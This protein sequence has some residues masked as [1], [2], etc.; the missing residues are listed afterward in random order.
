MAVLLD[1]FLET[2]SES[3]LM[4]AGR[5]QA[6]LDGLGADEKP[7]TGEELARLLVGHGKLTSFQAR[8]ICRGQTAGLVLGNY[9]VLDS[10]GAGGMGY[11][12]KARHE[13]MKRVVALKVLPSSLTEQTEAVERF[14]RE[15]EAAAKLVHRNIVVAHD[16]DEA[17]GLHF[18]VMEYVDGGD[19]RSLV[20]LIGTLAVGQAVDYILQA[21]QAL[22][23]AHQKQVIHRDVKPANLLLDR[24]GTIKL[25]DLGLARVET[26]ISPDDPTGS[27]SLTQLGQI[28]GT[29]DFMAPEQALD[30]KRAREPADVY[31]LGCTLFFLLTGRSLY[32]AATPMER[33]VAHR[34]QPIPSIR[35]LRSDVPESLDAVFRQMVAKR[36][37]DRQAS[38]TEVIAQLEACLPAE[39]RILGPWPYPSADVGKSAQA[40]SAAPADVPTQTWADD[41]SRSTGPRVES[42]SDRTAHPESKRQPRGK[43]AILVGGL[44]A[45]AA[46]GSVALTVV[47]RI[48]TPDGTLVLEISQ[49]GA[50]VVILDKDDQVEIERSGGPGSLQIS[51]DPGTY[52][53]EVQKEGFK[54]YTEHFTI[55]SNAAKELEAQLVPLAS[56]RTSKTTPDKGLE[57][58][59]TSPPPSSSR[60]PLT[61]APFS[62]E[63]AKQHQQVWGEYLGLPVEREIDL[64]GGVTLTTVL[65][66]PGEFLMGSKAEENARFMEKAKAASDQWTIAR[67]PSEGPQQL[68]RIGRPFWLS[69]YE[70]TR[71]QFRLF[72]DE[73]G[74]KTDA[75]R[76]KEGEG[77][78]AYIGGRPVRDPRFDWSVDPGFKQTD[79]HPVVNV[80]WNDAQ[81]FCKW[82]RQKQGGDRIVLP[83]EAQWEYACRAGTTT[84]WHCGDS[85]AVLQAYGWFLVN[86][87]GQTHPVGQL[88]PNGFG[89]YDMHG[90][91]W[92]WCAHVGDYSTRRP[93]GSRTMTRGGGIMARAEVCRSA[94]R[95]WSL[96][97]YCNA[98]LGFRVALEPADE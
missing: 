61:V 34:E 71:G 30:T 18:L 7:E 68:V 3:G 12:Y 84:Y 62:P 24:E 83:T 91:V 85:D 1:Q 90:N 75:A 72:V 23:Y 97:D 41:S 82:L 93:T 11:V 36:P 48:R 76:D 47:L 59:V 92:E 29:I 88:R 10:I 9:V 37:E 28:M 81:A 70:V 8:R 56:Q 89:L 6:F 35:E 33:I 43:R 52:R 27:D 95:C 96:P 55:E 60:S 98:R 57:P 17:D 42:N 64:G 58:S 69:R 22:E 19:L 15:V 45:V 65:I 79:D 14:E 53:L 32:L 80:S 44:V 5:V 50:R 40:A 16:A 4:T 38:M 73:T 21:A 2:L 67:I 94:F 25:L 77:G 31:S 13:R 46:L 86:S 63:E 51:V 87:G 78:Q 49:P 39:A 54:L 20:H 26:A 66:P 74:Y